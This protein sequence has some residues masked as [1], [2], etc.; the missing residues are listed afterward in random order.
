MNRVITALIGI[1]LLIWAVEFAPLPVFYGLIFIVMLLAL[2]EYYALVALPIPFRVAGFLLGSLALLMFTI[3][4]ASVILP[5]GLILMLMVALFARLELSIAFRSAAF[6]FFGALY[7]GGLMSFLIALRVMDAELGHRGNLLMML[8]CIIW[9]GDSFA[10]FAGKTLGRHKLAP[11]VSPKKTWEGAIAGF[12]FSILAAIICRYTFVQQ[13]TVMDSII[14][15]ALVGILGQIG[16]L[17]E[18]IVKRAANVKDSGQILP[19]HG[20]MLDRIDSLL[21]GA[22]AMYYYLSFFHS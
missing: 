19:G 13:L 9:V 22:S 11:V 18:S 21:F 16:D 17:C 15:G 2:H 8:F 20:G 7:V 3:P 6:G 5:T 1:P 4:Q 12:V 14:I 10:F